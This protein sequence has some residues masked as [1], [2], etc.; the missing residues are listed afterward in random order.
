MGSGNP[1]SGDHTYPASALPTSCPSRPIFLILNKHQRLLMLLITS[2]YSES[3]NNY[4]IFFVCPMQCSVISRSPS[5]SPIT[6]KQPAT[7]GCRLCFVFEKVS[8]WVAH[9]N[10]EFKCCPSCSQTHRNPPALGSQV[11]GLQEKA[12]VPIYSGLSRDLFLW[13]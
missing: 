12:T 8:C 6:K 1:C 2:F 9:F 10:P 3:P 7:M 11:L 5:F 4:Y 13:L